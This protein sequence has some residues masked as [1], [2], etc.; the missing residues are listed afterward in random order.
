VARHI[1][2]LNI[3]LMQGFDTN[4][5]LNEDDFACA[6]RRRDAAENGQNNLRAQMTLLLAQPGP[7]VF[8]LPLA[9]CALYGTLMTRYLVL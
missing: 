9:L 6:A 8:P 5:L 3:A 1:S 2:F 7:T 4:L